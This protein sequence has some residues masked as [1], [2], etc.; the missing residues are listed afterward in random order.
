MG[1]LPLSEAVARG[2]AFLNQKKK[3]WQTQIDPAKLAF[4]NTG[5]PLGQLFGSF[6]NGIY[7]LAT[8]GR[9]PT[10]LGFTEPWWHSDRKAARLELI[11]EWKK[12]L[13]NH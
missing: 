11:E 5:H 1:A 8:K 12:Q 2:I 3:G 10:H 4:T 13:Q 6:N 7:W 9:M